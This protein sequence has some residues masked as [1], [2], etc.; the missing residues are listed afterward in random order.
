[1]PCSF[2]TRRTLAHP[3]A[4]KEE[5]TISSVAEDVLA[6]SVGTILGLKESSPHIH[7]GNYQVL[8]QEQVQQRRWNHHQQNQ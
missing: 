5:V 4:G 3:R 8:V 6:G 2:M 1:M 7:H